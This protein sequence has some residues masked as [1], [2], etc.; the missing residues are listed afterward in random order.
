MQVRTL[1]LFRW[2]SMTPRSRAHLHLGRL[3]A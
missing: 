1:I 3:S 2:R